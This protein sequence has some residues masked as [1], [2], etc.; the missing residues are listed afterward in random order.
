MDVGE[1]AAQPSQQQ[2]ERA[3]LP[4][5]LRGS[6][7]SMDVGSDP[8]STTFTTNRAQEPPFSCCPIC[9]DALRDPVTT[10]CGHNFCLPCLEMTWG[11][12]VVGGPFSCPQCRTSFPARPELKKNTVLC[13]VVE[14][15]IPPKEKAEKWK[16]DADATGAA[17][18][19]VACD[20]CLQAEATR[21]CLT[22][23]ASFC[24]EHLKPHLD[25]PAF[26][27]HQL[28]LPLSDLQQRKCP[29]HNKLLDFYCKDHAGCICCFCFVQH[30]ACAAVP[31]QEAKEEKQVRSGGPHA[32]F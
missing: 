15:L 20:N 25:S 7:S 16:G 28:V 12:E 14:Q 8:G 31:I 4:S 32:L 26:K 30:K 13:K 10:P 6:S 19:K 29:E 21:T 24:L 11:D 2:H 3:R 5:C 17:A 18:P 23:M 9:L 1:A 22:C 27:G